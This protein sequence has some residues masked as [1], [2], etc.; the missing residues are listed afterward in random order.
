MKNFI[1]GII[2][3]FIFSAAI[4][5]ADI[6][7]APP[8]LQ[9][10]NVYTYLRQ[11]YENFHRLQVVTTNPDG[12]RRGKIGDMVLLQTGG[13]SYIEINTTG[14]TVWRGVILTDTP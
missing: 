5:T 14:S 13:N 7:P 10:V 3:G 2:M 6:L 4:A 1:L 12:N 8:P 11:I 9:D